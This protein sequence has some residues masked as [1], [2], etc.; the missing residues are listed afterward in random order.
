MVLLLGFFSVLALILLLFLIIH[1]GRYAY[2]LEKTSKGEVTGLIKIFGVF[3]GD[4]T[5]V[6]STYTDQVIHEYDGIQEYDNDL[7][8]WWKAGFGI[9][10]AFSVVYLVAYH[11][12]PTDLAPL[13]GDEYAMELAEAE[14]MYANVDQVYDGITEDVAQLDEAKGVYL[15]SCKACHGGVLEGGVGPNLAD[16]YW[17]H[18]AGV[19][20]VYHTI[21]YGV[22]EKGM[23]AWKSDYSNK[24]IYGLASYILSLKGSNPPNAKEPQG[25]LVTK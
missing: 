12:I 15:K 17:L 11:L 21:K 10:I 23:K 19:N 22:V 25:E 6:T 4:L 16:D 3:D 7:P 1:F 5:A 2:Q 13:Q 20:E 14:I 18:G 9:T 24:Q 8:P